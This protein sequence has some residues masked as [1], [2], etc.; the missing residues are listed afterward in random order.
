NTNNKLVQSIFAMKEQNPELANEMVHHLYE[1][2]LLSQKELEPSA[3]SQ[4]VSRSNKV[5]EHLMR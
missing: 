3:I 1:L 4:F 2:S 5:L